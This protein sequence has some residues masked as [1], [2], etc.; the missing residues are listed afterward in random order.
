MCTRFFCRTLH[1]E[2]VNILKGSGNRMHRSLRNFFISQHRIPILNQAP[3]EDAA[4]KLIHV[5][6]LLTR[7]QVVKHTPHPLETEFSYLLEREHQRYC[8]HES[9][10]SATHFM[11]QRGQT[12][13]TLN[14]ADPA[15]IQKNFFGLELYQDALKATLQRY[16]PETRLTERDFVDP[17]DPT[18]TDDAP[19]QRHALSRAL[20]DF[21]Y[22]LVKEASTGK[23]ALPYVV[24]RDNES[25][26]TAL[27]R[28]LR[29][30]NEEMLDFYVWS[31]APQAVVKSD[32]EGSAT[33]FV[34]HCT[35]LSGR[36][37]FD[38]MLPPMADHAWVRRTEVPQY[39][40]RFL[41]LP[42]FEAVMD[43][44]LDS[45]FDGSGM[46]HA[47]RDSSE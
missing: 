26:R 12:I 35:Y 36:P 8:R 47:R 9:S 24:R 4:G 15:E 11:A 38:Q 5:A 18:V 2:A 45:L 7:T 31:N 32:G 23:W 46:C 16:K 10:E 43:I 25:L 17:F 40:D 28:G 6:Y 20:D 39:R 29:E 37:K 34:Y 1:I 41:S 22:L 3:V 42:L 13:D 14:R 21:L 27:E 33:T 30:Q 19:P 44:T